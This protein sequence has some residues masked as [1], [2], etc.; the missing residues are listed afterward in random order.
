MADRYISDRFLPD[1][2]VDLIDEP[3]LDCVFAY[4]DSAGD[5][6]YD[7]RIEQVRQEKP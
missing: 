5:Q 6:E 7:A 3:V 4:V 2:A 1:K